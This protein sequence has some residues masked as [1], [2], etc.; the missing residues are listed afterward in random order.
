MERK[1]QWQKCQLRAKL[2]KIEFNCVNCVEFRCLWHYDIKR[3]AFVTCASDHRCFSTNQRKSGRKLI[4]PMRIHAT[5]AQEWRTLPLN[6]NRV[7]FIN[8]QLRQWLAHRI[9]VRRVSNSA[10]DCNWWL[11]LTLSSTIAL[12]SFFILLFSIFTCL[13]VERNYVFQVQRRRRSKIVCVGKTDQRHREWAEKERNS[14]RKT[15]TW[16]L[17][18]L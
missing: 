6:G 16:I 14:V 18:L 10:V 8:S 3:M 12:L 2:N 11:K 13:V 7:H 17:L 5:V 9:H 15:Q 4:K 1:K